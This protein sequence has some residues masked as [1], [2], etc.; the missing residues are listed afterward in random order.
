MPVRSVVRGK[1]SHRF[2]QIIFEKLSNPELRPD[3]TKDYSLY[4]LDPLEDIRSN[5]SMGQ[6]TDSS[7]GVAVGM[8]LMSEVL[9]PD[10]DDSILVTG[11]LVSSGKDE[12]ALEVVFS[13]RQVG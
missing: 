7:G 1:Y 8:G 6:K 12:Y 13:L 2:T 9:S 11:T 10:A 3:Y 4:V 5:P